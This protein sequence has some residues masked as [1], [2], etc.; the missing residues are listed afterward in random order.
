MDSAGKTRALQPFEVLGG[1]VICGIELP[2][3]GSCG[4]AHG[5]FAKLVEFLLLPQRGRRNVPQPG[6]IERND[7]ARAG[8]GS[9]IRNGRLVSFLE[10]R[11]LD[12]GTSWFAVRIDATAKVV[13]HQR[14]C[15]DNRGVSAG[16][17]H[18]AHE[19][20]DVGRVVAVICG[21]AFV[22]PNILDLVY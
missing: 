2:C 19:A 10:Y 11:R 12:G 5:R 20:A 9:G 3:V 4:G 13:R 17:T 22:G 21:I 1:L 14:H 8:A 16:V 18:Q 15:S 6:R 7:Q